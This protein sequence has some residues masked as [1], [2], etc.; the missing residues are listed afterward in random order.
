MFHCHMCE[1]SSC[2]LNKGL[3]WI[4]G[5]LKCTVIDRLIVCG[6]E[7][8]KSHYH[9]WKASHLQKATREVHTYIFGHITV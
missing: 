8:V 9:E 5:N 3:V 1:L 4:F 6:T 7:G 2:R